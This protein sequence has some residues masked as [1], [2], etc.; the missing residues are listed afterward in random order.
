MATLMLKKE[1]VAIHGGDLG[2]PSKMPG[3]ATGLD[4]RNCNVGGKLRP[5]KGSTC[6]E[7]YAF[8]GRYKQYAVAMEKAWAKRRAGLDNPKWV[9][10]MARLLRGESNFRWHDAGDLQGAWH[11]ARIV[12]VACLTPETSHWLPTREYKLVADYKRAG[13]FLPPNLV[14]RLSAPMVGAQMNTKTGTSS[15]VLAK[16]QETPAGVHKCPASTQSNECGDCRAC[17]APTVA[18]VAY[19][20]H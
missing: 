6:E 19:P 2:N 4:P 9:P 3:R 13:G 14:I 8:E 18:T 12:A 1:A 15:M 11:L 17:W 16:G 10:A 20:I 5:V 7:C